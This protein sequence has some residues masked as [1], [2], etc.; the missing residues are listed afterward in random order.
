MTIVTSWQEG[1]VA[2][3]AVRAMGSHDAISSSM[4]APLPTSLKMFVLDKNS[5]ERCD[6]RQ[7]DT[8]IFT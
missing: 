1:R 6:D 8:L 3:A 5:F 7:A 2:A 4:T